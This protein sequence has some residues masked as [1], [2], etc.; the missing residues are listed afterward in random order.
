MCR[1]YRLD[2]NFVANVSVSVHSI[3]WRV[4]GHPGEEPLNV[5]LEIL[6]GYA[7]HGLGSLSMPALKRFVEIKAMFDQWM[8]GELA[9]MPPSTEPNY[10]VD[11]ERR[12]QSGEL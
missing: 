2:E 5:R 12:R 7:H 8:S 10:P 4:P 6:D 9:E 3:E 11:L 1:Y